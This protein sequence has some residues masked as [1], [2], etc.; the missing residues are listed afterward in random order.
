MQCN[1]VYVVW[2]KLTKSGWALR[3][4]S[5]YFQYPQTFPSPWPLVGS[6]ANRLWDIL[7]FRENSPSQGKVGKL[8]KTIEKYGWKLL[9]RKC[10]GNG[11]GVAMLA[12]LSITRAASPS[13]SQ[14]SEKKKIQ[15]QFRF[16][17]LWS[18]FTDKPASG[19]ERL[20]EYGDCI[21]WKT[22]PACIKYE[23]R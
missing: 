7:Y 6:P 22:W 14:P 3:D 12:I 18:V 23:K 11:A 1:V 21:K 8:I 2:E 9:F 10:G 13:W 20:N 17:L 4:I 15:N 19:E 5:N 16:F